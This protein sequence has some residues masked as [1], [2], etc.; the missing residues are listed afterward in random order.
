M[1]SS[2]FAR[3]VVAFLVLPC[4]LASPAVAEEELA[5]LD[6]RIVPEASGLAVSRRDE[7]RLWLV[8]DSGNRAELVSFDLDS[9]SYSRVKIRGAENRDWEDLAAFTWGDDPWLAIADVGDNRA[10]RDRVQ[11]Y[12]LPEPDSGETSATPEVTLVLRYPDGPRDVESLAVD[13]LANA[14][15]LL[16]KRDSP[17]RLYRVELPPRGYTGRY[18]TVAVFVGEI[19]SIP[20]PDT[21]EITAHRRGRYRAQPTA[22][23]LLPDGSAIALMTYRGAYLATLDADR[24]WLQALNERLCPV[25]TPALEQGETLAADQQGRLYVT[26]EGRHPPL[27]RIAARCRENP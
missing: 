15:Y 13:P 12:L 21:A 1:T 19:H 16:S 23:T 20:A 7:R 3:L 25:T 2:W 17:P 4:V 8:N 18:E 27:Y 6:H 9:R 14:L 24:D 10:R 5:R 26:S 22:M 11:V